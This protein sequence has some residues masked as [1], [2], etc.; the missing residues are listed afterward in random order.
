V[1]GSSTFGGGD[2]RFAYPKASAAWDLTRY[3]G[4]TP[5]SFAKAHVAFGVAGKQPPV[6]SNVNAYLTST[7]TDGYLDPSGLYTIYRGN[8]GVVSETT[9]GNADISPERTRE[10]EAGVD[11]AFFKNRLS[12]GVTY[13]DAH[14][15][16]AILQL[17]V[18][19]STGFFD[20]FDN[21][22][23]FSN[24]GW[25][26]IAQLNVLDR[27]GLRWDVNAQ[28]GKNTSCV[29]D[30]AG[31]DEIGLTGFEGATNSVVSPEIA[32]E[33]GV[34][35]YPIGVFY[36]TDFVRFGRGIELDGVSI[37]AKYPGWAKG[38]LYIGADGFPVQDAQNRVTGDA[39]PDWTASL[40]NTFSL[41]DH[42]QIS[43]LV[44]VKRGG[45]AWNGTKGALYF[46][47][48]HADTEAYHGAGK[49]EVFGETYFTQWGAHGPGAGKSVPLNWATWFWNGIGSSFTGP[50]SQSIEDAGFVK[51]RDVSVTYS[52][53]GS[54]MLDR[55]GFSGVD[56]T[57]SGRNLRTWTDYTGIDPESNLNNQ[58]LGRGIDYFNNPQTRSFVASFTLTR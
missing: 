29:L 15:T 18:A 58:T 12:L 9:L 51:L 43:G 23:E 16:D 50:D 25:E 4:A 36:T 10:I 49:Q 19:P 17:D 39:N 56:V 30:L 40:R 28:W 20:K 35:C 53:R 44:D 13:Y 34:D 21:A 48:T 46:F 8:E 38:D 42:L 31:T 2:K 55:L 52:V 7:L 37:D 22:A 57:V 27:G 5:L 47:G 6:F 26:A 33:D 14:T 41:G 3:V 24:K 11:F 32:A 45:E 54:G 1:D